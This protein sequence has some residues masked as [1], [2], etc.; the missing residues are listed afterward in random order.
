[1]TGIFRDSATNLIWGAVTEPTLEELAK[2]T[3][4]AA[5]IV[6]AGITSVDWII[7]PRDGT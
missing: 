5:K 7:S 3:T 1:L 6:E 2:A 4:L